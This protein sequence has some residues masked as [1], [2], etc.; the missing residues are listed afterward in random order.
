MSE[1]WLTKSGNV[2]GCFRRGLRCTMRARLAERMRLRLLVT[3]HCLTPPADGRASQQV[4][5]S[6]GFWGASGRSEPAGSAIL[7][8]SGVRSA[9]VKRQGH[10]DGQQDTA[11]NFTAQFF[12]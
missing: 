7:N 1:V 3:T 2:R 4:R 6:V 10:V 8:R 11:H 12:F 5:L 9:T